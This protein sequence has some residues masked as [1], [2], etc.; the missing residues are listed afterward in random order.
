M[1]M[2]N[3]SEDF[4]IPYNLLLEIMCADPLCVVPLG[5]IVNGGMSYKPFT[6]KKLIITSNFHPRDIYPE[7]YNVLEQK[8]MKITHLRVCKDEQWVSDIVE[9]N[10]IYTLLKSLK[11][12]SLEDREFIR[13]KLNM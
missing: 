4:K 10:T 5:Q 9:E 2:D 8:G 13:S 11:D 12:L 6:S 1:V 7:G 3:C